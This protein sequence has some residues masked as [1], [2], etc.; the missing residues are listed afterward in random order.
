M[1]H[2]SGEVRESGP[3]VRAATATGTVPR[4]A[5][6]RGAVPRG[7]AGVLQQAP[8]GSRRRRVRGPRAM[9]TRS[10]AASVRPVQPARRAS[11]CVGLR[12]EP[13]I[14]RRP[15]AVSSVQVRRRRV[16]AAIGA[17]LAAA[18]VVVLLGLV[19]DAAGAARQSGSADPVSSFGG[20][21]LTGVVPAHG[22]VARTT[23]G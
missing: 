15:A 7:A 5:A 23:R 4:G 2:R 18:A 21:A 11:G 14:G 6:P 22:Q 8:P 9:R 20:S 17:A 3:P 10:L 1:R 16:A 13:G 19:A 12:A